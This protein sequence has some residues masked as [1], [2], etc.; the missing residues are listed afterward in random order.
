M[1]LTEVHMTRI[2]VAECIS[3]HLY[4]PKTS[5]TPCLRGDN[6]SIL[7]TECPGPTVM[8][9]TRDRTFS[10]ADAHPRV[11]HGQATVFGLGRQSKSG[12]KFPGGQCE[13]NPGPYLQPQSCL[14]P[15]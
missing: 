2:H 13:S 10:G 3:T 14:P 15:D 12:C 1:T 8:V 7:I 5:T 9:Q 4:K 11:G 6:A